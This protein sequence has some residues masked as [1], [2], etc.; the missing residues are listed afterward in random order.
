V[1]CWSNGSST[2]SGNHYVEVEI[3][4]TLELILDNQAPGTSRTGTWAVSGAP[5]PYAGQSLY[6][7]TLGASTTFT[8]TPAIPTTGTYDVYAWWTAHTNRATNVPYRITHA[9]GTATIPANQQL[10]GGRWVLLGTYT[11]NAGAGAKV[12]VSAENGQAC[13]DAVRFVKR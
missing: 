8:W 1:R 13:A 11:L 12:I 6:S 3:H 5:N 7:S 10:S 2:N 4:G 9:T